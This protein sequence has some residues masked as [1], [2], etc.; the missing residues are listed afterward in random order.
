MNWSMAV[1]TKASLSPQSYLSPAAT[2]NGGNHDDDPDW[3]PTPTR[4]LTP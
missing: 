1:R 3:L 2:Q 4:I